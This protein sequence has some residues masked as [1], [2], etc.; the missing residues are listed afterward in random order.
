MDVDAHTLELFE[1]M[2]QRWLLVGT[3][4]EDA[5]VRVPP[6]DAIEL[7]IGRIFMLKSE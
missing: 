5:L 4:G 6:F 7:A 1:L 2:E 3:Y